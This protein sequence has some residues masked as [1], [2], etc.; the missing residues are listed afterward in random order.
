MPNN[1]GEPFP[2]Y[3][4]SQITQRQNIH[5]AGSSPLNP[6][7]P[8]EIAYL[9]SKT[10]W[11]KLASG[12][13]IG[14]KFKPPE[15][16]NAGSQEKLAKK[17]VLFSG[18]SSL[19][20]GKLNPRGNSSTKNNIY[21]PNEG[22]YNV[23]PTGQDSGTMGLVP[24]PGIVDAEI[25]CENRGSVKKATVNIKCYSVEQFNILSTLYLRIGYTMLLE[26]GWNPYK[27]NTGE[28]ITDYPTLIEDD[29]GFFNNKWRKESYVGF[30]QLIEQYR[31]KHSGNY[32]GLLCKVEN[33][34]WT[35]SR[36]SYDIQLKLVSLGSIVES[37]TCKISPSSEVSSAIN[38]SYEIFN[39]V[40][41][42]DPASSANKVVPGP[43]S[44][45]IA[46]YLFIQKTYVI[47]PD[48]AG[49]YLKDDCPSTFGAFNTKLPVKSNFIKKTG[50]ASTLFPLQN[51]T[52]FIYFSYNTL[53][54]DEDVLNDDGFYVRFGHL[55]EFIQKEII[56]KIKGTDIPMIKLDTD[57]E[58]NRMYTFPYQVSLDPRV[59]IVRNT[60]EKL[61]TK[62]YHTTLP[63]W[64]NTTEG[65]S[66]TMNIYLNCNMVNKILEEKQDENGNI[67][68][69]DVFQSICT[70]LNK[71]LGG[72]NNLEPIINEE[73]NTLRFI[74]SSY[75]S[76]PKVDYILELYGYTNNTSNFVQDF[77]LKTEITNDL[78]LDT[79]IGATA[80]GYAKGT[81]STSFSKW[82]GGL[83]DI[84]KEEF[85]SPISPKNASDKEAVDNYVLEFW[86][87]RFSPFGVTSPQDIE[88]D[89]S[90]DDSC[91]LD[92]SLIDRN[93]SIV[94]EFYKYCQSRLHQEEQAYGS[95]TKGFLP[96]NMSLTFEG[97]SGIKIY[98]SLKVNTKFLPKRY[99]NE[100]YFII[101]GVNH[102][103]TNGAWSTTLTTVSV[104]RN[105]KEDGSPIFTYSQIQGKVLKIINSANVKVIE[106]SGIL[107]PQI[108]TPPKVSPVGSGLVSSAG[109]TNVI[110]PLGA[111]QESKIVSFIDTMIQSGGLTLDQAAAV[112]GNVLAESGF[113][114]WNVEN[115]RESS[116]GSGIGLMQWTGGFGTS[117]G[118]P[119][120]RKRF[121]IYV[122]NWLTN[123]GVTSPYI[124]GGV[125]DTNPASHNG[126][127]SL[128][129]NLKTIPKLFEAQLAL[130]V[131]HVTVTKSFVLKNFKGTLS[132]NTATLVSK[133]AFKN[134][135]GGRPALTLAGY[136]EIF[137]ADGEV[138]GVVVT[139][140]S[141]TGI[142]A[143]QKE[144]A[145]RY[146]LAVQALNTYKKKKP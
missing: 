99:P 79:T 49:Y 115:G 94:T 96:V 121:E 136:T 101:K 48:N 50:K 146:D 84:F 65:Y 86:N 20:D 41:P 23:N 46:A 42:T 116:R 11:V 78:A 77:N 76:P 53:V 29:D 70:E 59:C 145:K 87:K 117:G 44:N 30:L 135:S 43:V 47:S 17:Y 69:Y 57:V 66:K 67:S 142:D 74:D 125:L 128:E 2:T 15:G 35:F 13:K 18:I 37:L 80:S 139:A 64:K 141:G 33:F 3:V 45:L 89:S 22:V 75:L 10:A 1:I 61:N 26:W 118:T 19:K 93:L 32:D 144:V 127:A 104:P 132:G 63:I 95:P 28:Y 100:L 131:Q 82:N 68:L 81:D 60:G 31:S 38:S 85:V 14:S 56:P 110:S 106:E 114:E 72:V 111:D 119:S 98:N 108:I 21:D 126:G 71:A 129:T 123:N 124:K 16:I 103:I 62:K 25:K 6:R 138:P 143:Y 140:L 12:I 113:K 102:K 58:S 112:A 91:A 55:I 40:T 27:S 7:T 39:D 4:S 54:D 107:P 120:G 92:G 137:L 8:E 105:V 34:S 83:I 9:N 51:D 122:G 133:N 90:T 97:L 52:D 73:E 88:Y 36:G 5:G 130:A 134:L 109:S 24:M